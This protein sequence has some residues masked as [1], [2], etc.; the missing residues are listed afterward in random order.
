MCG[1]Y[2]DELLP[3]AAAA[4]LGQ[5]GADCFSRHFGL[6]AAGPGSGSTLPQGG[7]QSNHYILKALARWLCQGSSGSQASALK[8]Q[9]VGSRNPV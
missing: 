1:S 9:P 3:A 8:A 2:L 4:A 7:M 6:A 5:A